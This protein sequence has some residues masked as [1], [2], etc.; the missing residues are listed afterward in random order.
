M[1]AS[2]LSR[3]SGVPNATLSDWLAGRKPRNLD[4]VKKVAEVFGTTIDHLCYGAEAREQKE[5][6][7]SLEA[8]IDDKWLE[9]TFELKIRRV[10]K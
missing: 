7:V 10:K 4:Q 8:L 5:P 3:K 9:G 6:T 2:K 1:T